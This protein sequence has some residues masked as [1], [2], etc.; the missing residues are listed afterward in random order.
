MGRNL[1]SRQTA[2]VRHFYLRE[3]RNGAEDLTGMFRRSLFRTFLMREAIQIQLRGGQ[4]HCPS[5][6]IR[7]HLPRKLM[8]RWFITR[9]QL[10]NAFDFQRFGTGLHAENSLANGSF[11]NVNI[12][13]YKGM[14][15]AV[16]IMRISKFTTTR[17]VLLELKQMR[18]LTHEN[19][20]RLIG[21]TAEDPNVGVVM[22]FSPRGSLRVSRRS[23]L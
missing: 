5:A 3:R 20:I 10:V 15:V 6:E 21:L 9:H 1:L 14:K 19:L 16:R 7:G 23:T 13:I 11:G 22:E 8:P 17:S 2:E 12:G 18:D 4:R